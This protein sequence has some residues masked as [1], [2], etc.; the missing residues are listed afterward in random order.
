MQVEE[1]YNTFSIFKFKASNLWLGFDL[2]WDS[3]METSPQKRIS[4]L[5]PYSLNTTEESHRLTIC[6]KNLESA[7]T[8]T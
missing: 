4:S 3:A 2:S 7:K 1:C 5:Y 6:P 8:K